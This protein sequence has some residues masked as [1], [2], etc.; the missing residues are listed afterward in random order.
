MEKARGRYNANTQLAQLIALSEARRLNISSGQSLLH[1][2]RQEVKSMKGGKRPRPKGKKSAPLATSA[3]SPSLDIPNQTSSTP[4][5][6]PISTLDGQDE[7]LSL[8]LHG[9]K[10]K[11]E[12]YKSQSLADMDRGGDP[13]IVSVEVDI[14]PRKPGDKVAHS[15]KETSEKL[16]QGSKLQMMLEETKLSKQ[17]PEMRKY[18]ELLAKLRIPMLLSS[19]EVL[20]FGTKVVLQSLRTG[21]F[22]YFHENNHCVKGYNNKDNC[23]PGAVFTV[24]NMENPFDSSPVRYCDSIWLKLDPDT[25]T[26]HSNLESTPLQEVAHVVCSKM[27]VRDWGAME[28]KIEE[29][30]N[31]KAHNT[32]EVRQ[33]VSQRREA[34]LNEGNDSTYML[35]NC[36]Q[37][38]AA[39]CAW[40]RMS[41]KKMQNMKDTFREEDIRS[42]TIAKA[43]PHSFG[44]KDF[45]SIKASGRFRLRK[46][47]IE[48]PEEDDIGYHGFLEEEVHFLKKKAPNEAQVQNED[49]IFLEQGNM[50]LGTVPLEGQ[51]SGMPLFKQLDHRCD[52]L[53]RVD[54]HQKSEAAPRRLPYYSMD[55]NR[56]DAWKLHICSFMAPPKPPAGLEKTISNSETPSKAQQAPLPALPSASSC[57]D[58]SPIISQAKLQVESLRRSYM[59]KKNMPKNISKQMREASRSMN[60]ASI[61]RYVDPDHKQ[62][63]RFNM[64]LREEIAKSKNP[65]PNPNLYPYPNPNGPVKERKSM[66]LNN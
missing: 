44:A 66:L 55:A 4:A 60:L 13:F 29:K 26:N 18:E 23:P 31:F 28:Q 63:E 10:K 42:T 12:L 20:S 38:V 9:Q 27:Q 6:P 45:A 59:A 21:E 61:S 3:S 58:E 24:V 62:E 43:Q 22:L 34:A 2:L 1:V 46:C 51:V 35:E 37:P 64:L 49:S 14:H 7:I 54:P 39:A 19:K 25:V 11:K 32:W 56:L 33:W 17:D 30:D 8:L 36:Q 53:L 40:P 65:N 41:F 15:K 16:A 5:L 52:N 48:N 47:N 50:I 57:N